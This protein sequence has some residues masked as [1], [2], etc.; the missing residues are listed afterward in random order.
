MLWQREGDFPGLHQQTQDGGQR[1]VQIN[2]KQPVQR[3]LAGG[4]VCGGFNLLKE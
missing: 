1:G 2:F 3:G 4:C